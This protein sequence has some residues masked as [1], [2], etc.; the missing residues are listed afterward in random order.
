MRI[1]KLFYATVLSLIF[2]SIDAQT[3]RIPQNQLLSHILK[4]STPISNFIHVG[5]AKNTPLLPLK[6]IFK[7]FDQEWV[8]ATNGFY[9]IIQG[10]GQVYK[11]E[12]WNKKYVD[13]QRIDSTEYFGY[14]F[15][16][17]NFFFK[18]SLLSYGGY[19]FW[20]RNGVLR[21]FDKK[22]EWDRI[23]LNKEV[24]FL[25]EDYTF[26][27]DHSK[28]FF[29]L[30]QTGNDAIS[31]NPVID[32][33]YEVDVRSKLVKTLGKSNIDMKPFVNQ[34]SILTSF[35]RFY[36]DPLNTGTNFLLDFENNTIYE[37]I[38]K[39]SNDYAQ[40]LLNVSTNAEK[41]VIFF[42]NGFLY[43]SPS[44]FEKIDSVKFDLST[45]NNTHKK[46]YSELN[47]SQKDFSKLFTLT[48]YMLVG[49]LVVTISYFVY[50]IKKDQKLSVIPE[51]L[52]QPNE[53]KESLFTHLEK[54]FIKELL[55]RSE[56]KGYCTTDEINNILGVTQKTIE[57]Q[58]KART[59]FITRINY[60]FKQYYKTEAN[61]IVR[62]RSEKD[63][64]SFLYSI[65]K[66]NQILIA[67]C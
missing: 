18:D 41:G 56:K 26:N 12:K 1:K 59:D 5:P 8:K 15:G 38:N 28:F 39:G 27:N 54:G 40:Y 52:K 31:E 6:G 60:H 4:D 23:K 3:I 22:N 63:K 7:N 65:N 48:L 53:E 29:Y 21:Y 30:N 16:G 9:I 62:E 2:S 13:F 36:T 67:S 42:Q 57:I 47:S 17:L 51:I 24:P 37:T 66:E 32:S 25:S 44:P 34:F 55:N 45:F 35:G 64:R 19:G 61:L 10:S 33:F 43:A 46:I 20:H 50:S 58:K 14:N 11:A 49:I